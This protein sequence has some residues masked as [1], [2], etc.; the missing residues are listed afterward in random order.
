M[1][2]V[3]IA[4]TGGTIGMRRTA[5]GYAPEAGYMEALLAGFSELQD[6]RMPSYDIHEYEPLLDSSNM[7]PDHWL[8]IARDILDN[9]DKYDG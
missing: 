6:E 7:G 8:L 4:Y 9:Y 2:R 5:E 1:K 3:Y